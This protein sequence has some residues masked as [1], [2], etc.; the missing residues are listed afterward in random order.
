MSLSKRERPPL[1]RR[2]QYFSPFAAPRPLPPFRSSSPT[3]S[4]SQSPFLSHSSSQTHTPF[5]AFSRKSPR[6]SSVVHTRPYPCS[7]CSAALPIRQYHPQLLRFAFPPFFVQQILVRHTGGRTTL[8]APRSSLPPSFF[9]RFLFFCTLYAR[10]STTL[11]SPLL[12]FCRPFIRSRPHNRQH[13]HFDLR[14]FSLISLVLFNNPF[15]TRFASHRPSVILVFRP[16]GSSSSSSPSSTF[17]SLPNEPASRSQAFVVIFNH[18]LPASDCA[19][20][21][22]A[23]SPNS[24]DNVIKNVTRPLARRHRILQTQ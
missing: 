2:S 14:P 20:R 23:L 5:L 8:A 24:P 19:F 21:I 15:S 18:L 7:P 10:P 22:D 12:A 17:V 13:T 9:L 6:L 1:L 11:A 3:P 16:S 4:V